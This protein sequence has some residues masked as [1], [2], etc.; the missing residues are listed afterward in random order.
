MAPSH[1]GFGSLVVDRLVRQSLKAELRLDSGPERLLVAAAL[2][3]RQDSSDSFATTFGASF[4][5]DLTGTGTANQI[6][7]VTFCYIRSVARWL[8]VGKLAWV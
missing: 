5:T 4:K 8:H 3:A 7:A 2:L 1:K 6:A